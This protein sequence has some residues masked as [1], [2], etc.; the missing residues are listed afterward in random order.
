MRQDNQ[1]REKSEGRQAREGMECE[2]KQQWIKHK[3]RWRTEKKGMYE[4]DFKEKTSCR[5]N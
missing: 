1:I 5:G 4:E 2:R 3:D